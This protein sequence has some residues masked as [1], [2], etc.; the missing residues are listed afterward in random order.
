LQRAIFTDDTIGRG[1]F[2]APSPDLHRILFR[3]NVVQQHCQHNAK[4]TV[5]TDGNSCKNLEGTKEKK[6]NLEEV[7]N[8]IQSLPMKKNR[9]KAQ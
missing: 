9:Y 6:R 4:L 1:A 2:E 8:L 7:E 3:L 5:Q